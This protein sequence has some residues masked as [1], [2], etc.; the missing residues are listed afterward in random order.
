MSNYGFVSGQLKPYLK[1]IRTTRDC[2]LGGD[3]IKKEREKYL[4][5]FESTGDPL[6]DKKR[7]DDYLLRAQFFGVTGNTHE[8]LVG[9]LFRVEPIFELPENI[10]PMLQNSDGLGTSLFSL[11]KCFGGEVLESGMCGILSDFPV[12]KDENLSQEDV[13]KKNLIPR[14]IW[15]KREDVINWRYEAVNNKR[16]LVFLVLK[17]DYV[18]PDK[19]YEEEVIERVRIFQMKEGVCVVSAYDKKNGN[20]KLTEVERPI[21][22]ANNNTFDYIPFTPI[23]AKQNIIGENPVPLAPIADL[24]IGMYRNSADDE[25]STHMVGQPTPYIKGLTQDW[26]ESVLEKKMMIG[27]RS[28]IPL[29]VGADIGLLQAE[30][31]S[32]P[33]ERMKFKIEM[34]RMLGAA[35]VQEKGG[36]ATAT[37]ITLDAVTEQSVLASISDNLSKGIK[38]AIIIASEYFVKGGVNE[39]DVKITVNKDFDAGMF[40]TQENQGISGA[41]RSELISWTESRKMFRRMGWDLLEDEEALKEIEKNKNNEDI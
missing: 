29:P 38:T 12:V 6:K 1:R 2:I 17:E 11:T 34:C 40:N 41:F 9:E 39:E 37:E 7:Y 19:L 35:L 27:S 13:T 26:W 24:N 33:S 15:Y 22:K 21:K 31:N 4:P 20:W 10:Q 30:P 14:L 5:K 3:A 23:G 36:N 18:N 25:D 28:A 8:N 32:M 16:Q